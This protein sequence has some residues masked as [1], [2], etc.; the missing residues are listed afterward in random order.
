MANESKI[1]ELLAKRERAKLGGG[2]KNVLNRNI[3]RE[4]TPPANVLKN[5][6]MKEVLK[7]TICL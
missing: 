4:N 5:S 1:S 2:G 3:K 7:N 6:S